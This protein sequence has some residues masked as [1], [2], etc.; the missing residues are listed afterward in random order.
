MNISSLAKN[1]T[2]KEIKKA[3][4][5]AGLTQRAAADLI[6][7]SRRAWQEWESGRGT[8]RRVI[9]DAFQRAVK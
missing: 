9:L 1:P 5:A 4:L 6:G 8:M 7:Y 3:R 2:P